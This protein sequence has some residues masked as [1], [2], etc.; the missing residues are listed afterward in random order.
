MPTI[1]HAR[2]RVQNGD[3]APFSYGMTSDRVFYSLETQAGK[4][5]A[6]VL[7][8]SLPPSATAPI[9]GA[10][11]QRAAD[12]AHCEADVL[13]LIDAQGPHAQ[14][15]VA[16]PPQ[17]LQAVYCLPEV[18][19]AWGFDSSEPMIVVTDRN[20]RVIAVVEGDNEKTLVEAAL[21]NIAAAP[22]E[23]Q[24]DV[25]LPAPVLLLPNIFSADFCRAL[26]DHFESSAHIA[27]GMASI[28]AS[29]NAIH[30]IDEG[31][32]KREDYVLPP[33]NPLGASVLDALSR[34][35]A[36]EMKKAFQCDISHIDRMIIA[37]YDDT[38]GYFRRHRDNAA[39]SVAFRQFAL[40][41]NLNSE[42]Y[43]GG[44]LLFPEYNSHRYKPERGAGIAFSASLLHE[45]T[46]VIKG[47]RY[48]LLTFLHNAEGE[49]RRLAQ[50]REQSAAAHKPVDA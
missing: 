14:D 21:F 27:G 15:Y 25:L 19:H 24:R 41:I 44:Y 32:K 37:C 2:C 16:D 40:S 39:E 9:V 17:G 8:G 36:P 12:F 3:R 5:A 22:A 28:D 33:D 48:V 4:P 1:E 34:I 42:A 13:L 43:E 45:A 11:R 29:G 18:F 23:A 20:M 26:I 38:G 6:V 46:P 31:K 47:R 49:T 30:K 50:L 35:C 10:L 7:A